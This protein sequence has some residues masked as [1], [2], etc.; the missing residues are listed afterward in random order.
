MITSV[1]LRGCLYLMA[2]AANSVTS[3]VTN[4]AVIGA[5]SYQGGK[6]VLGIFLLEL[7]FESLQPT[8]TWGRLL[9]LFVSHL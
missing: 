3:S 1:F 2:R 4:N 9:K 6:A 8:V 7:P 5:V